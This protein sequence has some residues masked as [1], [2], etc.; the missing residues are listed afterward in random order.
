SYR[1]LGVSFSLALISACGAGSSNAPA[2][3]TGAWSAEEPPPP[4]QVD[5]IQPMPVQPA[6]TPAAPNINPFENAQF[7][8]DPVYVKKVQSSIDQAPDKAAQLKKLQSVPTA[9]WIDRIEMVA[10]VPVWLEDAAKKEK[11]A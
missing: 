1:Y 11:A 4:L 2:S 8:V 6:T 7:Y 3:T 9:L 5:I 10:Q